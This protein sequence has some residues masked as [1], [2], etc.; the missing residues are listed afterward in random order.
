MNKKCS[1]STFWSSL[2]IVSLHS[3]F[4]KSFDHFLFIWHERWKMTLLTFYD[5][6]MFS[7]K[8]SNKWAMSATLHFLEATLPE[9]AWQCHYC[10][11]SNEGRIPKGVQNWIWMCKQWKMF[12]CALRNSWNNFNFLYGEVSEICGTKV[13]RKNHPLNR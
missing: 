12:M 5:V 13:M 10:F 11:T 7:L 3:E 9:V 1:H 6:C 2:C 4:I 8:A